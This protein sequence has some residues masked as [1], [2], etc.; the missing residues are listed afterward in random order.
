[1]STNASALG[2]SI[3]KP[4]FTTRGGSPP[5]GPSLST[6]ETHMCADTDEICAELDCEF[7]LM[8]GG[9]ELGYTPDE[10]HEKR[11]AEGEAFRDLLREA[12]HDPL[13]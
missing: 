4:P 6:Q 12:R 8:R 9:C 11:H 7:L 10:C 3:H 13:R 2:R 1:M 5:D